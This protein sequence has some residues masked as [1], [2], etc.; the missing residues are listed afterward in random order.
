MQLGIKQIETIELPGPKTF[1][2]N[3]PIK[4][5]T[6]AH[7]HSFNCFFLNHGNSRLKPFQTQPFLGDFHYAWKVSHILNDVTLKCTK[8][9]PNQRY[10]YGLLLHDYIY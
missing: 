6:I 7:F 3:N 2:S 1:V 9:I 5:K 8:N 10:E 4:T